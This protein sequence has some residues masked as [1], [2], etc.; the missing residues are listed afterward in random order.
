M[1]KFPHDQFAKE[2]LQELLS[3][4]GK[5][6]T[7]KN[8]TA[9]VR[10]I[11]VLFQP[12]SANPEYVQTLGLLGK[13]VGTVALI[14]P[15]RNAV[16]PEEI[17]SCVSKLLDNRA[18]ALRNAN[19]ESR[20]LESTQLP[21]LWILT[22][23]A[24]ENLLNSFGLRTPEESENWERGVYFLSDVWRVGLIVVH[25]LPKTP[26]TMW[27]RVLGKGRVQ[28]EAIAE[29]NGLSADNPLRANALE[30]L[31]ALQVN[32]QANLAN[33]T[34]GDRDDRELIM[35]ITPLFQEQLQAAQQQGLQ[36]GIQQGLQQGIQQGLQQGIERGIEQGIEQGLEQGIERGRQE[37][38]RLIL[39]NFLQ[40][41]FGELDPKMAAFLVAASTLPA[42]EFTMMLLSISMLSVDETGRQQALKLLAEN[43][44]R[45]RSP[46]WGDLLPSVVTNLLELPDE[47]FRLF[48]EQLPQLSIEELMALLGQNSG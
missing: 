44:L 17:F 23:T 3:P 25:Q 9:E 40:V 14:E 6:D 39:E 27:L 45:M 35:A 24:S 19:R 30:L 1:T 33:N 43:I 12:T 26:E 29:L 11:D 8:L 16:S 36:E 28:Q 42:A 31:Y 47:Q 10:E 20:R 4:L 38:Q 2:Y 48:L 37:Q 13:M 34:E 22:P 21:F 7:G 46:E 5:V 18:K 32:L 41:R 15:F